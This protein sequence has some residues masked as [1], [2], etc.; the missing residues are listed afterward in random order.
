MGKRVVAL[1][2]VNLAFVFAFG[3]LAQAYVRDNGPDM[4]DLELSFRA[5]VFQQ[6]TGLWIKAGG[7]EAIA[8]A[9][10]TVATVDLFFPIAYAALL[11]QLYVWLRE[12]DGRVALRPLVWLPYAA[13][14]F[15]YLENALL[16][17]WLLPR[18][19]QL[20][21]LPVLLMS[22]A[23]VAKLSLLAVSLAFS[24]A[25]LIGGDRGRVLRTARYSL[26]SLLIGT[27]PLI[28]TGQGRDLLVTL[29]SAAKPWYPASF[30]FWLSVWAFSVW[31]WSRVLLKAEGG[32]NPSALF[33]TWA[34]WLPRVAGALTL[35]GPAAAFALALPR[36][37]DHQPAM[38]GLGLTCVLLGVLFMIFVHLR[39]RWIVRTQRP[40]LTAFDH[41]AV[42]GGTRLVLVA[43]LLVSL[44]LFAWMVIDPL[45]SGRL[46]GAV[47]I[48]TIAAANTVFF[49]SLVVFLT[50]AHGVPIEFV[51]F[52][53]AAVFSF[54]NDNH[55]VRLASIDAGAPVRPPLTDVFQSW[56]GD[57]PA[58]GTQAKAV[59]VF[60]VAAEGGGLRAGYWTAAVLNRLDR[61]HEAFAR[62][63]F[64]ISSVSGSSYGAAV[65]AGLQADQV[66][67]P[68]RAGIV[69]TIFTG[70]FLAPNL[71]A[72]VTGDFAQW[73]LPVPVPFFDRSQAMERSFAAAYRDPTHSTRIS[74]PF[75]DLRP[76]GSRTVPLLFL[77]GTSV[78]SGRRIVAAPVLWSP[79]DP[80]TSGPD[81]ADLHTLIR[82][83]VSVAAAVHNTA[84]FPYISAAGRLRAASG[85]DRGHIVDGGYFE[86]TGADT[87]RDVISVLQATNPSP[88]IRFVVL[89]LRNTPE[90]ERLQPENEAAW[91]PVQQL[92]EIIAPLRALLRTR[93]ARGENAL[94]RLGLLVGGENVIEFAV[95]P[96][97]SQ[98]QRAEA[99]LGWE[100]SVEMIGLLDGQLQRCASD[101]ST[102]VG[103]ILSGER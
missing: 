6:I 36:T 64:A 99:P 72:L 68:A 19:G 29:S 23:A 18:A 45:R 67:G 51:A 22:L 60:M 59:P 70:G 65:Y 50:R 16:V 24:V 75:L 39:R 90:R 57:L 15:D 3:Y 34:E 30:A 61:D 1:F 87:L 20:T 53:G 31:Y 79:L 71:A 35:F 14:G 102:Q 83:D 12:S 11:S 37:V 8:R 10:W 86:N 7:A 54:W 9:R 41:A 27:L 47:P 56:L 91:R 63:L 66:D 89:V 81:L 52:A 42:P 82:A 100:L 62:H 38:I 103:Q 97:P 21:D 49:G 88:A 85:A 73:F 46:L 84:R 48:L 28:A 78:D 95:C 26:I 33:S 101:A 58:V 98:A 32:A 69:R 76:A 93:E 96:D 94:R 77:N 2:A 43:S 4:L 13:A 5:G 74:G 80:T 40:E 25:E 92:G 44:S 17:F 55:D